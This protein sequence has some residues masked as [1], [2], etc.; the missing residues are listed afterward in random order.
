MSSSPRAAI[1]DKVVD[2]D[3]AA[4]LV[5]D[6]AT[7]AI[8]GSGGGIL[9]ADEIY[10]AI[11]RRFLATGSPRDLTLIHGL[12]IGDGQTTGV[13]RFAHEGMTRRVIGGHWS[14][15]PAMQRLALERRIEAYSLPAGVIA[16]LLRESGAGRPGLFTK[17]GIGSFVDPRLGGGRLNDV[18]TDELVEVVEVDGEEFLRYRPLRVDVGVVRGSAADPA[19]NLSW[20]E[21]AAC[22][23]SQAI[24]IA[25]RGNG[26]V[27]L[28]Q[29]KEIVD[30]GTL[31]PRL[32]SIPGP[33]VDRVVACPGQWQTF[34]A[35]HEAAFNSSALEVGPVIAPVTAVDELRSIV[36]RRAADE[37][38]DG[39]VINLGYGMSAGVVDV[40]AEAGRLDDVQIVIEQGA[41]GGYPE[42]GDLFGLSRAPQ[43]LVSSLLQFDFF[44]T[45]VIDTAVLGMAQVDRHGNVNVS[46]VGD[47]SVGPGGFIDIVHGARTVVF[48]GS[49]TARGLRVRATGDGLSVVSEGATAKFVDEVA[50][51]T[52]DAAA[53]RARGQRAIYVTERAVF[54]LGDDALVLI[55]VAPGIDLE[56]EVL[57]QMDFAPVIGALAPM[58]AHAFGAPVTP[59]P[60]DA[61]PDSVP[62]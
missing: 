13:T 39:S 8:C 27:V 37:V 55:E 52:F 25:A 51:V 62:S 12:G 17:V 41:V 6:G 24:A 49:F 48:C 1:F 21:E 23:D 29:A 5:P 50:Q 26:G 60:L 34:A 4:A 22:L 56:T 42:S 54:E 2:A 31:D 61:V 58:P 15:S 59:D 33:M 36:A 7:I 30:P 38:A 32:I 44:A 43:A 35:E 11:E 14:W 28:A 53:A 57:A 3:T 20:A 16:T 45:G 46:L 47:R 19:G 9:E 40:L 18:G 10:A